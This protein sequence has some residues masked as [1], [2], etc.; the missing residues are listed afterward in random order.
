MKSSDLFQKKLASNSLQPDPYRHEFVS[1]KLLEALVKKYSHTANEYGWLDA[2]I[3]SELDEK[4][5]S[6]LSGAIKG[7][8]QESIDLLAGQ[9]NAVRMNQVTSISLLRDQLTRLSNI[10]ANVGVIAGRLLS[11]LNR[12]SAASGN[13]GLRG[14]GITD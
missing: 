5:P 13:D 9:T 6:T 14:Q 7:A 8:S 12:L 3:N 11:I 4:D 2:L 10:D 1:C